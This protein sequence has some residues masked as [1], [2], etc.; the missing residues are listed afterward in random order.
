M[1]AATLPVTIDMRSLALPSTVRMGHSDKNGFGLY[2]RSPIPRGGLVYA[3]KVELLP[4][5][6]GA[7]SATAILPAELSRWRD[8]T[9]ELSTSRVPVG[10]GTP[11][12]HTNAHMSPVY[13]C[14]GRNLSY[15]SD[16]DVFIN[17]GGDASNVRYGG[18]WES[19]LPS[20]MV[21]LT[22]VAVK[23]VAA[24]EELLVDYRSRTPPQ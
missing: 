18:M 22:V 5:P 1:P 10:C 7:A 6:A 13:G 3:S 4:C 23:D 15:A 8:S 16:L 19:A 2:A 20:R 21:V 24:G 17:H 11:D 14:G 9:I 12:W